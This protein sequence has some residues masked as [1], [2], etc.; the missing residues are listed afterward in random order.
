MA[1][2]QKAKQ[3][4]AK[5]KQVVQR[6]QLKSTTSQLQEASLECNE[7]A[8]TSETTVTP[9]EGPGIDAVAK[10]RQADT[11]RADSISS[12]TYESQSSCTQRS[13]CADP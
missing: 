1:Q 9:D 8:S 3:L 13:N 4:H 10:R 7:S 11:D 2:L 12:S 6:E 5:Q